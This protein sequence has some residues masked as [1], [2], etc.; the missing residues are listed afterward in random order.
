MCALLCVYAAP[1]QLYPCLQW[2]QWLVSCFYFTKLILEELG[3][4]WWGPSLHSLQQKHLVHHVLRMVHLT[5]C[6]FSVYLVIWI[7]VV[8]SLDPS[9]ANRSSIPSYHPV[10][11]L[12]NHAKVDECMIRVFTKPASS[13]VA[14]YLWFY[15][16]SSPQTK[17]GKSNLREFWRKKIR[18]FWVNSK[19]FC[20]GEGAAPSAEGRRTLKQKQS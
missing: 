8:L 12:P 15:S 10:A 6:I 20:G 17:G 3:G 14:L 18:P 16:L 13:R 11:S 7:L 19:S 2:I 5:I 4:R 1:G 9:E